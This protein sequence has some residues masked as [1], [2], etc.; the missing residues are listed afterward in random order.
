[1][2]QTDWVVKAKKEWQKHPFCEACKP[3]LFDQI[4][5]FF[6]FEVDQIILEM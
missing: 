1:M 6:L 2:E 3:G 5:H 4:N